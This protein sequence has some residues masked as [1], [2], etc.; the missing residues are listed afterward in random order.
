[1]N[2]VTQEFDA[3]ADRTLAQVRSERRRNLIIVIVLAI[4][5][6]GLVG[7]SLAAYANHRADQA[8][9][10]AIDDL[11]K[12]CEDGTIDCSGARGLPGPKGEVGSSVISVKCKQGQFVFG[13][14]SGKTFT[15][16]DCIARDGRDG[17]PG[18]RG[19]QGPPGPRGFSGKQ[20]P[21]GPRGFP[22]KQGPHGKPG[23]R[24]NPGHR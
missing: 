22:G 16:G 3:V 21:P 14:T 15:V 24:G 11:K 5:G 9:Q 4:L 19:P 12:L 6:L 1:M 2:D 20:G 17:K 13:M 7:S 23:P 10:T 8:R 18:A